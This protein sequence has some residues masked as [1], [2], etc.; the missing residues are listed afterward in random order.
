MEINIL[1]KGAETRFLIDQ[2]VCLCEVAGSNP[3]TFQVTGDILD[4]KSVEGGYPYV[5]GALVLFKGPYREAKFISE[6][7]NY[8]GGISCHG[9]YLFLLEELE[10]RKT[11]GWIYSE[12]GLVK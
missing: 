1:F 11:M 6:T 3:K 2:G 5:K 12:R 9:T 10:M 7:I 8:R 4:E